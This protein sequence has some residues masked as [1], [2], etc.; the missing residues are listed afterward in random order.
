LTAHWGDPDPVAAAGTPAE[1]ALAFKDSYR[2]LNQRI[3]RW[4]AEHAVTEGL[5]TAFLLAAVVGSWHHGGEARR[6]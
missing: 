6:R 4:L 1:I 3:G 2:T 5:G